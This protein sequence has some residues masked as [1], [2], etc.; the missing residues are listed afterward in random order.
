MVN[1]EYIA[2]IVLCDTEFLSA[3]HAYSD[4]ISFFCCAGG[5]NDG[6]AIT[7]SSIAGCTVAGR[8]AAIGFISRRTGRTSV[9]RRGILLYLTI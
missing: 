1:V 6:T 2:L 5:R 7:G 4:A 8:T 9:G 3:F